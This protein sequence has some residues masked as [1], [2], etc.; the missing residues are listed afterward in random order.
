MDTLRLQIV[1]WGG[2]YLNYQ[3]GSLNNTFF[4]YDLRE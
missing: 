1:K 2:G 3:N 4:H